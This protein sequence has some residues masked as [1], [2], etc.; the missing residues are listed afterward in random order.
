MHTWKLSIQAQFH[1]YLY[2][3]IHYYTNN[4]MDLVIQYHRIIYCMKWSLP[5]SVEI[6]E[7]PSYFSVL[8]VVI[9]CF[10]TEVLLKPF[11][12]DYLQRLKRHIGLSGIYRKPEILSGHI[13]LFRQELWNT[14]CS[15]CIHW[16]QSFSQARWQVLVC[17]IDSRR[18]GDS[19]TDGQWTISEMGCDDQSPQSSVLLWVAWW[20]RVNHWQA[21]Q[22][23]AEGIHHKRIQRNL[24]IQSDISKL[25]GKKGKILILSQFLWYSGVKLGVGDFI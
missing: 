23:L 24:K 14:P 19:L 13:L 9:N 25:D 22:G 7:M 12:L 16:M 8:K 6:Q 11:T 20:I 21:C 15:V 1:S 10:L 2:K 17:A 3:F 5:L 4:E 18:F